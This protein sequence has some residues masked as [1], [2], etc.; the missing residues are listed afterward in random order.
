MA[1]QENEKLDLATIN[2]LA[3]GVLPRQHHRSGVYIVEQEFTHKRKQSVGST[4]RPQRYPRL[5][6]LNLRKLIAE[7]FIRP[8]TQKELDAMKAVVAPERLRPTIAP[9]R[10]GWYEV[11]F[12]GEVHKAQGLEAADAMAEELWYKDKDGDG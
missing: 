2:E 4:F 3:D 11:T 5:R 9:L 7:G 6:P 10:G 1:E 8:V 12:K